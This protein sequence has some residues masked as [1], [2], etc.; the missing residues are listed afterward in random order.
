MVYGPNGA[1]VVPW[2][3]QPREDI[4]TETALAIDH[5]I[6]SLTANSTELTPQSSDLTNSGIL[7]RANGKRGEPQ[8]IDMGIM[9]IYICKLGTR[10]HCDR[11]TRKRTTKGFHQ[12]RPD[13]RVP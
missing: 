1:T 5:Q 4:L 2:G 6:V 8:L 11:R 13:Y 3:H 10:E 7:C 9:S 12:S